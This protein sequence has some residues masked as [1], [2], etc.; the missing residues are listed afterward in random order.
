[1][2]PAT[3]TSLLRDRNGRVL[4][5]PL[6]AL[7]DNRGAYYFSGADLM[8]ILAE[9]RRRRRWWWLGSI[10][11]FVVVVGFICWSFGLR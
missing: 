11:R 4:L 5:P 1:M 6:Q 3:V 2:F 9:T 8:A 10:A 7:N